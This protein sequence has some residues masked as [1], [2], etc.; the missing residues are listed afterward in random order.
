MLEQQK[1]MDLHVSESGSSDNLQLVDKVAVLEEAMATKTLEV[2]RLEQAQ[3]GYQARSKVGHSFSIPS[4]VN[5]TV[6]CA[7][8]SA[9]PFYDVGQCAQRCH[10]HAVL[11]SPLGWL[12]PSPGCILHDCTLQDIAQSL[13]LHTQPRAYTSVYV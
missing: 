4:H 10:V 3:E 11:L 6:D 5:T 9:V 8:W 7:N 12:T 1:S 2:R 13:L